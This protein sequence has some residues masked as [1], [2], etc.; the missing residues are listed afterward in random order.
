VK[1][2]PAATYTRTLGKTYEVRRRIEGSQWDELR[3]VGWITHLPPGWL[4]T[5]ADTCVHPL[6]GGYQESFGACIQESFQACIPDRVGGVDGTE[7]RELIP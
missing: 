2:R 6:F 4:W 3:V 1:K 5:P 7:S